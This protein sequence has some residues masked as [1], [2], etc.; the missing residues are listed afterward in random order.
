MSAPA[1]AHLE[2]LG[3]SASCVDVLRHLWDYIDDEI[4]ASSA[5]RLRAHIASCA[6]CSEFEGFQTCFLES[7][8]RLRRELDAP[9]SVRERLAEKLRGE[10]C[11]CWEQAR[12][13][14][15]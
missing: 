15:R 3:L 12:K 1:R 11:R 10:G 13:Q 2:G 4:T 9:S 5:E 14:Q 8:A 7:V 6:Q